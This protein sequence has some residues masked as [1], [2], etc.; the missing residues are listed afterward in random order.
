MHDASGTCDNQGPMT[1]PFLR[2]AG[3]KRQLLPVI[4]AAVECAP[5]QSVRRYFE[6]FLGGAAVYLDLFGTS[7]GHSMKIESAVLSDLN[8]DLVNCYEVVRDQIESLIGKLELLS[9]DTSESKF[10]EI[11]GQELTDPVDRAARLI[12]L[13]RLCFNGLYRLNRSGKFNVPYG[14]L[15]NPVVCNHSL[16]RECSNTLQAAKVSRSDFHNALDEVGPG[17]LVYLDPPY[18]PLPDSLSFSSY[19]NSPFGDA[20]HRRLAEV[21]ERLT[22]RKALVVLSNSDTPFTRSTFQDLHRYSVLARRNIGASSASRSPV[23]ELIATNFELD[24]GRFE[25]FDF[26]PIV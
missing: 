22:D 7:A 15:K 4:H 26:E 21:A 24:P 14:K 6:P 11:R 25:N 5:R 9:Q 19:H 10:Y 17:D 16:L 13:N 20:E 23:R 8:E 18:A 1:A 3:G 12:Y 2:W